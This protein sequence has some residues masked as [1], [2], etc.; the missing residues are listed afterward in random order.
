LP[1]NLPKGPLSAAP[2]IDTPP[3]DVGIEIIAMVFSK[4]I[5]I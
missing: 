5:D 4:K 1:N 3:I 2:G